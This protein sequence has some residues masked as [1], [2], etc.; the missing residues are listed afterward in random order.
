MQQLVCH[1]ALREMKFGKL[2]KG[3]ENCNSADFWGFIIEL[4]LKHKSSKTVKKVVSWYQYLPKLISRKNMWQIIMK[5]PHSSE[6]YFIYVL[7]GP[8]RLFR[9]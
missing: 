3:F 9:H 2:R 4:N 6:L 1:Y 5:Y 8:K 7:Y